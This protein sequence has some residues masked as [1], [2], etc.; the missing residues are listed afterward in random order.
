[1][2]NQS[3]YRNSPLEHGKY[4]S[5][6]RDGGKSYKGSGSTPE[7]ARSAAHAK[8]VKGKKNS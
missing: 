4:S 5:V 2:A 8:A 7:D 3:T 6:I 1:M